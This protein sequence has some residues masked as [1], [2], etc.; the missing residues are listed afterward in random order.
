MLAH[1][2]YQRAY[3]AA[4]GDLEAWAATQLDVAIVDLEHG[5]DFWRLRLAPHAVNACP[6]ELILHRHQRA[7]LTIGPETYED[8]PIGDFAVYRKLLEAI[9]AGNV[10]IERWESAAT[11]AVEK[12]ETIVRLGGGGT[13]RDRRDLAP[14][15]DALKVAQYFVK[16]RR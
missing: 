9:A 6:V 4:T 1:D 2:V 10:V 14:V 16:Y 5:A 11:G 15:R 12:V 7:D 13:W 8:R 3:D